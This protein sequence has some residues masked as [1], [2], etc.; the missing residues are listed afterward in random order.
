MN[1][2]KKLSV[3]FKVCVK[4]DD[5]LALNV[6]AIAVPHMISDERIPKIT[7]YVYGQADEKKIA[8]MY[9]LNKGNAYKFGTDFMDGYD[10]SFPPHA[11]GFHE[12]Y[13]N[14]RLRT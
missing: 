4:P 11:S 12:Y 1:G 8:A 13:G 5:L 6:D 9:T 3:D 10:N 14:K 2:G 7:Q